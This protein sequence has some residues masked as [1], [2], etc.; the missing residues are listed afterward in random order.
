M[1]KIH[2]SLRLLLLKAEREKSLVI[3]CERN[4]AHVLR[5]QI[6][7]F[8]NKV[9][10]AKVPDDALLAVID[11]LMLR[12]V[13]EGLEICSKLKTPEM[14]AVLQ[15]LGDEAKA[16]GAAPA[17]PDLTPEEQA[18][19]DKVLEMLG[20]VAPAPKANKYYER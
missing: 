6:Y 13:D 1:T 18:S 9:K 19:R 3:P 10:K 14:E 8:M 20:Q 12:L 7:N 11:D 5:M 4:R 16:A 15:V 17:A 2:D